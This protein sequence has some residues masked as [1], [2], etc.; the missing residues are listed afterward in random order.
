ML[1]CWY[2]VIH[3]IYTNFFTVTSLH[4]CNFYI[5]FI[6]LSITVK[7]LSVEC[8][9]LFSFVHHHQRWLLC[10]HALSR[11]LMGLCITHPSGGDEIIV[12]CHACVLVCVSVYVWHAATHMLTQQY[13]FSFSTGTASICRLQTGSTAGVLMPN[14]YHLLF[15]LSYSLIYQFV[16]HLW[17]SSISQVSL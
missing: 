15:S 16:W 3:Y 1:Y 12:Q 5:T 10:K 17:N 14:V 7:S 8:F 2:Y 6:F 9:A 11:A 13:S 4:Y